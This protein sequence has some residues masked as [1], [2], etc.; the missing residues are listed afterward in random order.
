MVAY[1]TLTFRHS[2]QGADEFHAAGG[3]LGEVRVIV[4]D[5]N[6]EARASEIDT[7]LR[8]SNVWKKKSSFVL[9]F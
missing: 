1:R 7:T 9:G 5:Q 2:A 3:G 6:R 4:V 8:V